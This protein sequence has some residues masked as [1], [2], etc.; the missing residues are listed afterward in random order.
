MA[1]EC[2]D[3]ISYH[4]YHDFAFQV[5]RANYLRRV[6]ER[7]LV[8]TEWMNRITGNRFQECYPM[9]FLEKIGA[10]SW[11]L[12][13]RSDHPSS[14]EPWPSLWTQYEAGRGDDVD[15][16]KWMHDLYRPSLRPYDPKEV[17]LIKRF[18]KLADGQKGL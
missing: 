10:V 2:S 16:T 18:N 11:G 8:N 1:L 3:V 14:S 15:F 7:P 12:V 5:T 9:F 17:E 6:T 4:C 13:R